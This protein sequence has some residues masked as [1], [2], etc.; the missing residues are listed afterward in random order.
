M[1]TL[2]RSKTLQFSSKHKWSHTWKKKW[3]NPKSSELSSNGLTYIIKGW[4][5]NMG[6]TTEADK[7][8]D[9]HLHPDSLSGWAKL[10]D[11]SIFLSFYRLDPTT[12]LYRFLN[13][14]KEIP[15]TMFSFS[16]KLFHQLTPAFQ[17]WHLVIQGVSHLLRQISNNYVLKY[18]YYTD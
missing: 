3:I 18:N 9:T 16:F 1:N 2:K 17:P 13:L 11:C 10:S 6:T 15:S 4:C 7:L 12:K 8:Q 14:R 5:F